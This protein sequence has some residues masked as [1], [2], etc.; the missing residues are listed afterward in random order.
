[1]TNLPSLRDPGHINL[2]LFA[3]DASEASI[4]SRSTHPPLLLCTVCLTLLLEAACCVL[5]SFFGFF[6]SRGAFE[7]F[8]I[9]SQSANGVNLPVGRTHARNPTASPAVAQCLLRRGGLGPTARATLM[10]TTYV[11]GVP[12]ICDTR[13]IR[14]VVHQSVSHHATV[15]SG[16][17]PP[18]TSLFGFFWEYRTSLFY[19]ILFYS[20]LV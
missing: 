7:V 10:R 8:L 2:Q 5:R 14:G 9:V 20:I 4:D 17:G 18:R 1:M 13:V 11:G 6:L 15:V 16:P 12:R 19:S 3:P